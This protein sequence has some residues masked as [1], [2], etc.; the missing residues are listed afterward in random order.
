[1]LPPSRISD[2][3][4][5]TVSCARAYLR[6][7]PHVIHSVSSSFIQAKVLSFSSLLAYFLFRSR[8]SRIISISLLFSRSSCASSL[9]LIPTYFPPL[10]LTPPPLPHCVHVALPFSLLFLFPAY[11]RLY[12]STLSFLVPSFSC[13]PN[14]FLSL[15]LSVSLFFRLFC[16]PTSLIL[17]FARAPHSHLSRLPF[18]LLVYTLMTRPPAHPFLSH[19]RSFVFVAYV[20]VITLLLFSLRVHHRGGD[21]SAYCVLVSLSLSRSRFATLVPPARTFRPTSI[22]SFLLPPIVPPSLSRGPKVYSLIA[23]PVKNLAGS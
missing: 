14:R 3:G 21:S 16:S 11:T 19:L 15:F 18:R 10:F 9:R 17:L 6:N 13:L 20:A 2:K 1:M 5:K 4:I 22:I 7:V 23:G 12:F 8:A